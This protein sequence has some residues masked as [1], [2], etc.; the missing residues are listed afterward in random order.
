MKT[1]FTYKEFT[2][3]AGV[4]VALII[5]LT[6]WLRP[7]SAKSGD[8]SRKLLPPLAKPAAKALIEKAVITIQHYLE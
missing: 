6:L 3:L 8:V 4:V 2:L 5:V 1:K 7:D